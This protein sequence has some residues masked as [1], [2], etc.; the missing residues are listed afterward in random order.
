MMRLRYTAHSIYANL[1]LLCC[2]AVFKF[3]YFIAGGF[4]VCFICLP[5]ISV[6][7][8]EPEPHKNF[9]P[10]QEMNKFYGAVQHCISVK[11]NKFV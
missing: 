6:V 3:A 7:L 1:Q 9:Y 8:R 11:R 5:G 2:I 4:T 10:E